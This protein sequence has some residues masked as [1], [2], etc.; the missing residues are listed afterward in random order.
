MQNNA[1]KFYEESGVA[2]PLNLFFTFVCTSILIIPISY[3]YSLFITYFPLIYF[4]VIVV[5]LYGYGIALLSVLF[6]K[7]F[8]LRNKKKA[9]IITLTAA[10]F[11]FYCQWVSY[12]Y[13]I[14]SED[15]SL[16]F[17]PH[18]YFKLFVIPF[19]FFEDIVFLNTIGTWEVFSTVFKGTILWLIW[20]SE[21][22][23][24]MATAYFGFS[25]IKTAPFSEIDNKWYKKEVFDSNFETIK[26]RT[27]FIEAYKEDPF[28]AISN[29]EPGN[30][31]RYANIYIH[32]STNKNKILLSI[33]NVV[34]TERGKGKKDIEEILAPNFIDSTSFMQ[35]K[36]KYKIK[37][38]SLLDFFRALYP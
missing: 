37:K 32:S 8:K 11:A 24:I 10:L 26:L 16:F 17:D 19:D 13:I 7:I 23:I 21:L 34:I 2:R 25:K 38:S 14:S 31:I 20:T 9:L 4:N 33:E 1:I 29:L 30:G 6:G 12:L 22:L 36:N 3:F 5:V 18:L 15:V 28:T 35:L 27:N